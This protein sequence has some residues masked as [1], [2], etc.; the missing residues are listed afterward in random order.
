MLLYV[1]LDIKVSGRS[2]LLAELPFAGESYAIPRIDARRDLDREG[3]LL[4]QAPLAVAVRTGILDNG[5]RTLTVRA[6]L[7]DREEALLH[8]HLAGATACGTSFGLGAGLGAR[9]AAVMALHQGRD[10]DLDLLARDRVLQGQREVIAQIR[11]PMNAPPAATTS[12][13]DVAEHVPKDVAEALGASGSATEPAR[14][15]HTRMTELVVSRS[16]LG[17]AQDLVGELGLLELL[18][19]RR[20]RVAVRVELHGEASVGLLDVGLAGVAADAEYFVIIALG[21]FS[22]V[23]SGQLSVGSI[24]SS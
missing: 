2:T 7:L 21:H 17:V 6:S 18:L 16:L 11:S 19:R 20:T 23:V 24:R 13:E 14:G 15:V 10:A 12:A 22:K 5:A 1:D 9:A 3:L 8:S 4:L